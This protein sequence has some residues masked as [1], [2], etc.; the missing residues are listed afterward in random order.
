MN[1]KD[2]LKQAAEAGRQ[3]KAIDDQQQAEQRAAAERQRAAELQALTDVANKHLETLP[4]R[5]QA[6]AKRGEA[7]CIA[8]VIETK[9]INFPREYYDGQP[10]EPGDL[11]GLSRRIFELLQEAELEPKVVVPAAGLF[12]IKLMVP[13]A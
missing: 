10:L 12:L 13:A 7:E 9:D 8:H 6:A 11:K 1:L 4:T 3:E 2:Q 5:I